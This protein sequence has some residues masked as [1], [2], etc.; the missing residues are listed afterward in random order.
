MQNVDKREETRWN[1]SNDPV[2][3][4]GRDRGQV[5]KMESEVYP[6]VL[7]EKSSRCSP[8]RSRRNWMHSDDNTRYG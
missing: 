6:E 2:D 8:G 4:Y 7:S 5:G 1:G 3:F